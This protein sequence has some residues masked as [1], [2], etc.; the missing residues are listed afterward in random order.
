MSAP[1][2]SGILFLLLCAIAAV[3]WIPFAARRRPVDRRLRDLALVVRAGERF[4]DRNFGRGLLKW[5]AENVPTPGPDS[6][7]AQRLRQTLVEAGFSGSDRAI[8]WFY[9]KRLAV[10]AAATSFGALIGLLFGS[11]RLDIAICAGA[12]A[13]VGLAAPSYYIKR[14]ARLRQTTI[15]NELSDV[16]DLLV[17]SV[18]AGMGIAEAIRV[19]GTESQRQGRLIGREL[20]IVAAEMAA[21]RS[22]AESLRS[23]AERSA[24]DDL[25]PLAATLIQSEQLGAQIGPA[26]R[27]SSDTLR[28]TRR[29]HAEEATQRL[30]V[31]ILFPLTF[32]VLPAML[33][34]T[35]GPTVIE[36]VK[37]FS[38]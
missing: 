16:L 2:V 37:T 1:A 3:L 5:A 33:M 26:L 29:L 34:L 15:A 12:G 18:E 19:I 28:A 38:H 4:V 7:A 6:P 11:E 8:G 30:S 31:K 17:I 24:V 20:A 10:A 22:M 14:K 36:I 21:G 27:A 32:L 9:L 23:M 13:V 35:V 25:K